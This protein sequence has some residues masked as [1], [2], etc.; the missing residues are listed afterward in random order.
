[1]TD[2]TERLF[3]CQALSRYHLNDPMR[4]IIA[5]V[6]GTLAVRGAP[7]QLGLR[8]Y[9]HD[10]NGPAHRRD[11]EQ[12]FHRGRERRSK[13]AGQSAASGTT[14][15]TEHHTNSRLVMIF[16]PWTE[17]FLQ[18]SKDGRVNGTGNP[19]SENGEFSMEFFA[20][21]LEMSKF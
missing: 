1:M 5:I 10:A 18:V 12:V 19:Y 16:N 7:F 4:L 17:H 15:A 9:D 13:N 8:G 2:I 6:L 20:T 21:S 14:Q 3:S 11:D